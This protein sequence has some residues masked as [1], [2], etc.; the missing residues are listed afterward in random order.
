[1]LLELTVNVGLHFLVVHGAALGGLETGGYRLTNVLGAQV[2]G[3]DDHRV[4]EVNHAPL[5]VREVSVFKDLQQR[6]EN[7]RV[8]FFNLIE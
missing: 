2:G 8:G 5:G 6:V 7:V 1:M 4:L 3:H